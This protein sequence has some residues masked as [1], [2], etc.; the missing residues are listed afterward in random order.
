MSLYEIQIDEPLIKVPKATPPSFAGTSLSLPGDFKSP[1][2][3]VVPITI[4][5]GQGEKW[6][7]V[8]IVVSL[9]MALYLTSTDILGSAFGMFTEDKVIQAIA[10]LKYNNMGKFL[11]NLGGPM[12]FGFLDNFGMMIG[13]EVVENIVKKAGIGDSD[14]IAMLGNTISDG[15]GALAGGSIGS[16]ITAWTAYDGSSSPIMELVGVM[17]GCLIP[18]IAKMGGEPTLALLRMLMF[19]LSIPYWMLFRNGKEL[20]YM[21]ADGQPI[22]TADGTA[23]AK[24][25][26]DQM[27]VEMGG[28]SE[29]GPVQYGC[30]AVIAASLGCLMYMFMAGRAEF[31]DDIEKQNQFVEAIAA[32]SLRYD[33]NPNYN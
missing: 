21:G 6:A 18:P 10:G 30:T 12:I 11:T 3:D 20:K 16:A 22:K 7:K 17:L 31:M 23:N 26:T 8:L 9:A 29:A 4:F 1:E 2:V 27:F 28:I 32:A 25:G 33:F 19:P 13:M 15:I 14:V 5:K 24:I